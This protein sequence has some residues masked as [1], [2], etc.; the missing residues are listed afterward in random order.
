IRAVFAGSRQRATAIGLWSTSSGAALA[1]GP[2]LGGLLVAG[3]GWRAVFWFN[4]PLAA[5]LAAA[6]ARYLPRLP[7]VPARGPFDWPSA[8]LITAAVALLAVGVIEGQARGWASAPVV[9]AFAGGAAALA[10]FAAASVR[11]ADPLIDLSLLRS[12]AF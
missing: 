4:V 5:A 6:G 11:R 10:G 2:P 7:R 3:L 9:A 12:Y 1:V 8:V